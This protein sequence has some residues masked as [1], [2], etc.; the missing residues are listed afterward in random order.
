MTRIGVFVRHFGTNIAGVVNV[1]EKYVWLD[2]P[3][4]PFAQIS[5]FLEE[6]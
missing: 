1:A 5:C 3:V 2:G 4:F 6:F